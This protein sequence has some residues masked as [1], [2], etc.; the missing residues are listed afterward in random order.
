MGHFNI[1]FN[2]LIVQPLFIWCVHA[3]AARAVAVF[4]CFIFVLKKYAVFTL[5]TFAGF[6]IQRS[7]NFQPCM[8]AKLK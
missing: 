7:V 6:A 1:P 8:T 4:Y 5:H 3:M 2:V